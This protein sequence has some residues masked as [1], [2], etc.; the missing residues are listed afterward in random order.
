MG[1]AQ[2][3]PSADGQK[4]RPPSSSSRLRVK[5]PAGPDLQVVGTSAGLQKRA[6]PYSTRH[7]CRRRAVPARSRRARVSHLPKR[8][9]E[10]RH[11][12]RRGKG[13]PDKADAVA[14]ILRLAANSALKDPH[15]QF[16]ALVAAA[17]PGSRVPPTPK[18]ADRKIRAAPSP[19]S[20][21]G[22]SSAWAASR[23]HRAKGK[24]IA[25][26]FAYFAGRASIGIAP[27][28]YIDS[29]GEVM[30]GSQ[31]CPGCSNSRTGFR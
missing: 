28:T 5:K 14:H 2:P 7:A 24:I 6:R 19:A 11:R 1:I 8:R 13:G 15:A 18:R 31:S 29:Y 3:Q 21:P 23:G 10:C 30:P 17:G 20:A 26:A 27:S 22:S 16:A 9:P 4:V 12:C 25:P